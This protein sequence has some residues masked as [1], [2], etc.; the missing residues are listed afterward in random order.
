MNTS[1]TISLLK[2]MRMTPMANEFRKQLDNPEDYRQ[3]PFE[4]RFGMIV[5]AEWANRQANKLKRCINGAHFSCPGAALEDVEYFEDRKLNK[6]QILQLATCQY[7]AEG[8]D[9]ILRGAS[10]NGK[11]IWPVHWVTL[12]VG[13]FIRFV[14]CGCRNCWMRS[15][16]QGLAA[17]CERS[18][19]PTSGSIC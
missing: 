7:I 5:D 15:G 8:R 12:P 14:T 19:G 11:R 16:S 13:I 3:I 18:S 17:K 10:G 4:D 6:A 9:I 2:E 1:E